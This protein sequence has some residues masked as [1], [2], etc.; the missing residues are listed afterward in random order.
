MSKT[1]LAERAKM[2]PETDAFFVSERH[3]PL[4]RKTVWLA[5]RTYGEHAGL[6]AGLSWLKRLVALADHVP[7]CKQLLST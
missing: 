5:L 2:P 1:W 4:S 6:L 7:S 3:G